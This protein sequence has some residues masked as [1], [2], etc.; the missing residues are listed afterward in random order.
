M[1]KRFLDFSEYL[2]SLER[3]RF[4]YWIDNIRVTHIFF[5][6][7]GLV[8][9]FG[10]FYYF[11]S[12]NLGLLYSPILK[13]PISNIFDAVYFS[14]ITATSTG[15]GDIVPQGFFSIIAI[16]EVTLGL[17]LLALVTSKLVATKQNLILGE[18]YE[19]SFHEKIHRLRSNLLLFRQQISRLTTHVEY[20]DYQKREIQDIYIYFD[21]FA[22]TLEEVKA[23]AGNGKKHTFSKSISLV[24]LELLLNSILQSFMRIHE[25]LSL[26]KTEDWQRPISRNLLKKSCSLVEEIFANLSSQYSSKQDIQEIHRETKSYCKNILSFIKK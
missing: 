11:F 16:F 10:F 1:K 24:D 4:T 7:I 8:L 12:G 5:L 23:I 25:L 20:N 6:W 18:I 15:F 14:F 9:I 21:S 3:K 26:L 13:Q 2:E 17:L 19:I 22:R